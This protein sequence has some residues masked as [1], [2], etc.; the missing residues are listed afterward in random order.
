[1]SGAHVSTDEFFVDLCSTPNG[2]LRLEA[3]TSNSPQWCNVDIQVSPKQGP[4]VIEINPMPA[5][6]LPEG[7]QWEDPVIEHSLPGGHRGPIN[8]TIAIYLLQQEDS[9]TAGNNVAREYDSVAS[10]YDTSLAT[11]TNYPSLLAKA[12]SKYD[13]GGTVLDS[14][15]GT[16]KS[17]PY[18]QGDQWCWEP[19][20]LYWC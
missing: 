10:G 18:P 3:L 8:I 6:F 17:R 11:N 12:V 15:S 7:H 14:G 19:L 9:E 2:K 16:G 20:H 13:L 1:M 5:I 4:V